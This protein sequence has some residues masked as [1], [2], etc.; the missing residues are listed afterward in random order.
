MLKKLFVIILYGGFVGMDFYV[1]LQDM[2]NS[3]KY[4][5][6]CCR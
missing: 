2:V 1:N 4:R 6:V 3:P 5:I